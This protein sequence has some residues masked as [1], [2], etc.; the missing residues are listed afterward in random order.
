MRRQ[1]E[2]PEI[3]DEPA[4]SILADR[5]SVF[6]DVLSLQ[7]SEEG[8]L[9]EEEAKKC[10][11]PL[12]LGEDRA[13]PDK[14]KKEPR[15]DLGTDDCLFDKEG[16][17]NKREFL[18]RLGKIG[19]LTLTSFAFVGIPQKEAWADDCTAAKYPTPE[20]GDE[21]PRKYDS[22]QSGP[23]VDGADLCSAPHTGAE[24]YPGWNAGDE[25]RM[26]FYNGKYSEHGGDICKPPYTTAAGDSCLNVKKDPWVEE[27]DTP[28]QQ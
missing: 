9:L 2:R 12:H 27:P 17:I 5:M 20:S 23:E 16:L 15:N 4:M 25:C 24:N 6:A 3:Q 18:K 1:R 8:V 19:G 22:G 21:C 28:D 13:M 7:G 26:S 10:P 14:G 11:Q